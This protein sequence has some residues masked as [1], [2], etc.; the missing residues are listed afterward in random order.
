MMTRSLLRVQPYELGLEDGFIVVHDIKKFNR[1]TAPHG[2]YRMMV[3]PFIYD[4]NG[5]K[6]TVDEGDVIAIVDD[7]KYISHKNV[8]EIS[9]KNR[10]RETQHSL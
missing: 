6:Q 1:L 8:Y 2:C 3:V 5:D 10:N 4:E 9:K 7:K